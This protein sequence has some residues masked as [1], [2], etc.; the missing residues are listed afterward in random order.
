MV[1]YSHDKFD[2]RLTISTC[3]YYVFIIRG[4]I[5]MWQSQRHMLLIIDTIWLSQELMMVLPQFDFAQTFH[6]SYC[7]VSG[8]SSSVCIW[9]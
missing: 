5:I 1:R 3:P 4:I 2:L 6:Q 9:V 7:E 8:I